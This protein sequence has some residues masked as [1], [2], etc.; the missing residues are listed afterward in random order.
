MNV[1]SRLIATYKTETLTRYPFCVSTSQGQAKGSNE[2][3]PN[4]DW[5]FKKAK[6]WAGR[7]RKTKNSLSPLWTDRE[8]EVG[9]VSFVTRIM[10]VT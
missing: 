10:R 6:K 3:N 4:V 7:V 5:F 2:M 1:S 8:T 9:G